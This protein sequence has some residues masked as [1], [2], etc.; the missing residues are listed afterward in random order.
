MFRFSGSRSVQSVCKRVIRTT[1][2]CH[3]NGHITL[4]Q[5]QTGRL[6]SSASTSSTDKN[7]LRTIQGAIDSLDTFS[8]RLIQVSKLVDKQHVLISSSGLIENQ[9]ITLPQVIL[10]SRDTDPEEFQRGTAIRDLVL[11]T[12]KAADEE[13]RDLAG[14]YGSIAQQMETG[15]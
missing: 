2:I 14:A 9:E 5:A 11:E 6:S 4:I 1:R 12:A 8:S 7:P 15:K 13:L 10:H 3:N